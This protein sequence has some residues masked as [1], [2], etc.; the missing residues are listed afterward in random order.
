MA[1]LTVAPIPRCPSTPSSIVFGSPSSPTVYMRIAEFEPPVITCRPSGVYANTVGPGV[2]GH[3]SLCELLARSPS[4]LTGW[5]AARANRFGSHC[6]SDPK[7]LYRPDKINQ[8]QRS[9]EQGEAW[10]WSAQ[11]G[12]VRDASRRAAAYLLTQLGR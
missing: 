2:S 6:S 5:S 1:I 8:T 10:W 4:L 7:G 12:E 3:V 11:R 9:V